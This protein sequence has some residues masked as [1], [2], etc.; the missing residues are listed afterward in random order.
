MGLVAEQKLEVERKLEPSLEF[1][2]LVLEVQLELEQRKLEPGL[3]LLPLELEVWQELLPV[4]LEMQP[5]LGL[6]LE[7]PLPELDVGRE[8]EL[9]PV[10]ELP[11]E[12]LL[13]RME[14]WLDPTRLE[15]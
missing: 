11:L 8:L 14:V 3:E 7:V 4:E 12:V 13:C 2:P 15:L 5:E 10:L 6:V 9:L 1:L